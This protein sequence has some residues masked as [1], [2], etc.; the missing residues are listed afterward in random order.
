MLDNDQGDFDKENNRHFTWKINVYFV[1]ND[2]SKG[3]KKYNTA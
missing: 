1:V 3:K 2:Q